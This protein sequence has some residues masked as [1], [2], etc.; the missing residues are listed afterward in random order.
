MKSLEEIKTILRENRDIIRVRY[1][2]ELIGLF[3]SYVRGDTHKD[4]DLDVLVEFYETASLLDHA[5]LQNYLT[6][7]VGIRVDVVPRK[8]I[9]KELKERILNETVSL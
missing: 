5:A 8:N 4:S 3:G 2:A 7:L 9:R 1:K 6:D